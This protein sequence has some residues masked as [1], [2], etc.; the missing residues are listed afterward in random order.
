MNVKEDW[1]EH[2]LTWSARF[3]KM[4]SHALSQSFVKEDPLAPAEQVLL[5]PPVLHGIVSHERQV[6]TCRN[7]HGLNS[8]S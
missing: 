3:G 8:C 4:T 2:V 6:A 7:N 5:G 1:Y